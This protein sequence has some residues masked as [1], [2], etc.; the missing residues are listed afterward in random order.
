MKYLKFKE[1]DKI[2]EFILNND[3]G[4]EI[5]STDFLGKWL[6]LYFYPKDNT[7]GCT[8]EALDFSQSISEFNK[9]NCEVVGISP[10]PVEKH[11]KF[12]E[13]NDLK[14]ILL[15]DPEHVVLERFGVWQLKKMYGKETWGVVRTTLLIDPHGVIKKIWENV[16]VKNHVYEVLDT[17]KN[18][19]KQ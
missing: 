3:E 16:K 2:P 13:K 14:V 12:K 9:H 18:M 8:T 4:K 10:D 17:L 5:K 19:N 15:S 11:I 6:V 7:P 1:G